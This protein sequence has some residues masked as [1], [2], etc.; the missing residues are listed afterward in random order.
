MKKITLKIVLFSVFVFTKTTG[1]CQNVVLMTCEDGTFNKLSS[2]GVF[3]N[4][5]GESAA[6]V[7]IVN[8]PN[9]TGV[10]TSAKV[11]RYVRRTD[12]SATPFAA[13][14]S[15][16]TDPDPSFT[17][18]KY[19]HVKVLKTK[20]S[21]VKFKIE[22]GPGGDFEVASTLPY[23]TAGVWQDMVFHF[24]TATGVYPTVI[25]FPDFED[26]L[27]LNTGN[28]IIHFD[29]IYVSNSP[30][31]DNSSLAVN[32]N[33]LKSKV[34]IY[35]TQVT[36][37]LNIVTEENLASISIFNIQGAKIYESKNL[38]LGSNQINTLALS[39][40]LYIINILSQNGE[41]FNQKLLK[42]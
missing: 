42:I 2:M 41:N 12:A 27:T 7:T 3:G 32:S 22:G 25:F 26:P 21:P 6:D 10:N 28:I 30:T 1:Y 40:G 5:N 8:N 39:N 23:A 35:P 16:I 17:V 33:F 20:L 24:P 18:N 4:G 15:G 11:A 29:E 14:F 38:K 9:A 13:A 34:S 31:P 36:T 19:V 37:V